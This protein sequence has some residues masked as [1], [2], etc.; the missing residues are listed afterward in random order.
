MRE[1]TEQELVRREKC[2]K[3]RELG[4]DPFGHKFERSATAMEIKDKYKDIDHEA[5]ENMDDEATVAGRIMFIRKMGKAS[6]FTIKDK[7][8]PIQIY[9]SI[10]D[11]GE[12]AYTLFK[13]ADIGDIVGVRGKIMR[14]KTG[15]V[16]IKCLEYTHL[17]KAL[18][19]L[20]EKFHGLTD[21]EER[22]RRRYVDL[23][24]NEEAKK[25][26]LRNTNFEDSYGGHDD[27]VS[28]AREFAKLLKEC[29]KN[30]T[31]KKVFTT[32]QKKLSN[33]LVA[34]NG[35][36]GYSIFHGLDEN[37]ITGSKSGYTPE[38]GLLLASTA[39]IND[40]N[41]MLI[42]MKCDI[43]DYMSTHVL[44]SYRIYDYISN[45]RFAT[46]TVIRKDEIIKRI[47][48]EN[49]TI[50][51]YVVMA[52]KDIKVNLPEELLNK[53]ELDYHIATKITPANKV[54]DNLGY[55]DILVEGEIINTY[56]I[57]LRDEIFT[58]PKKTNDPTIIIIIAIVFFA[59]VIMCT[60]LFQVKK[61][62]FK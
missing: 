7:T 16:T 36:R 43:N 40:T 28:T 19:P 18:K 50:N 34:F 45:L 62:K 14:T 3:L 58:Y 35:T 24:M 41:Y 54:G 23:I 53:V 13:S 52:E 15:E 25:L 10:N 39:T 4:M 55:I 11:I 29:L 12:E 44:E 2:A 27:N 49:G 9:I 46:K 38:A 60:N 26:G 8:G 32:Y 56:N 57:Y 20:P 59:L 61:R 51:E 42:V 17:V 33:D 37:L 31:F 22:Y 30:Q 6:F 48:V 47:P 5:F 21:I 1:F